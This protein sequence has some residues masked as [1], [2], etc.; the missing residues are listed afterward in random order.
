MKT[1]NLRFSDSEYKKL[2]NAREIDLALGNQ[3]SSW[4]KWIIDIAERIIVDAPGH[5]DE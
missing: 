4:E 3:G 5:D 2:N 1:L